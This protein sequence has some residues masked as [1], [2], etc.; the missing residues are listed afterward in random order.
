M[1]R[2]RVLMLITELSM[3]GAARM[4]RELSNSLRQDM[5]VVEAVFNHADGVDFPGSQVPTSLDVGGGG[6]PV[7]KVMNL[8]RRVSRTRRLKRLL[9]IDVSISHLEGAHWVDVLSRDREKVILCMHGSIVH[10][11]DIRGA[12]GRLRSRVVLPLICRRAD[13][14]VTVSRGI[15]DELASL[16][17]DRRRIVAIPNG[18]DLSSI[19]RRASEALTPEEGKLLDGPPVLIATGRLAAQKNHA[20]LLDVFAALRR[21]RPCRLLIAGD[22]PLRSDLLQQ[23]HAL[24]LTVGEPWTGQL[25]PAEPHVVFLGVQANPFRFITRADLYVMTSGWEGFPLALCEAMACG[26][27]VVTTDCATGPREILSDGASAPPGK[28]VLPEHTPAGVLMPLLHDPA[29]YRQARACWADL[30]GDLLDKP[31]QRAAL[32]R[33]ARDRVKAFGQAAIASRWEKL[34]REV[35]AG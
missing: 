23:A 10:N 13:R 21:R 5:D 7:A 30:L 27:P 31:E 19:E 18:F 17:V 11:G 29:T 22:G 9:K 34:I 3:G 1:A 8:A 28:L 2:T 4:V 6:G 26:T 16:G 20:A 25:Q 35:L 14:I 12:G 24:G 15:A 33:G 32:A